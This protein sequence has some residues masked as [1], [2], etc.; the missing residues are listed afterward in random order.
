LAESLE[1]TL[2]A[3]DLTGSEIEDAGWLDGLHDFELTLTD[4]RALLFRDC[5][6]VSLHRPPAELA[7]ATVGGWWTDEPSP[8]LLTLDP[9]V[10]FQYQHLVVE[11]GAA[12]LR[13]AFRKLELVL[14]DE[15]LEEPSPNGHSGL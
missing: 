1:E 10:R 3:L 13:L 14:L 11:I 15:D 9:A 2:Q 12:V 5:L 8:V 7:S 4:G 6:Q